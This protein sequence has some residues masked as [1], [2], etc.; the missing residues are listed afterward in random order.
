LPNPIRTIGDHIR[1]SR[2]ANGLTQ[3]QVAEEIGV[4]ATA[5]GEWETNK[6]TPSERFLPRITSFVGYEPIRAVHV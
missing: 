4:T 1:I 2:L 3:A 6:R 5:I